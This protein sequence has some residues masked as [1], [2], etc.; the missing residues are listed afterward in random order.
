MATKETESKVQSGYV[1]NWQKG[2]SV[3]ESLGYSLEEKIL[4][5]VTFIVGGNR[6]RIQAHRLILSLRSCVFMAML[7]G[8][9][10]EQDDIEIPDIDSD[11]FDQFVR[12]LYTDIISIDGRNVIRLLYASKSTTSLIWKT[13][14]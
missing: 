4:C 6:K 8:P 1:D 14:A 3:I 2:K 10:A 12:F 5:D 13:N 11:V 9:L 7:T